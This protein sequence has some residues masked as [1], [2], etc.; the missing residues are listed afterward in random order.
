MRHVAQKGLIVTW[1]IFIQKNHFNI[2]S[3]MFVAKLHVEG[4]VVIVKRITLQWHLQKMMWREKMQ[5]YDTDFRKRVYM[6]L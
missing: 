4:S 1:I 5:K 3:S 6:C 2:L